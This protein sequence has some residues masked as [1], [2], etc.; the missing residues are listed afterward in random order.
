MQQILCCHSTFIDLSTPDHTGMTLLHYLAWSSKTSGEEFRKYH[1][2]SRTSL[3]AINAEGQTILHLAAQRGN[4]TIID[5]IAQTAKNLNELVN[6]RDCIGRTA[7]HLGTENKRTAD[8]ITLLLS[9]GADI[10]VRDCYGRSALHH[11]AKMGRVRAAETL[12]AARKP[13]M[14]SELYVVDIW[15]MT[16]VM[17]SAFYG[18]SDVAAW[19]RG[20]KARLMS[21]SQGGASESL[22]MQ[23][24]PSPKDK[25]F[26]LPTQTKTSGGRTL[27]KRRWKR[28]PDIWKL[29]RLWPLPAQCFLGLWLIASMVLIWRVGFFLLVAR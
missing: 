20:E 12:V 10:R 11:A 23:T 17:V 28:G 26:D 13:D 18:K 14:A 3:R 19:L 1:Q 5:Y 6:L 27:I 16:P 21:R 29:E 9:L 25:Y 2:L 22:S 24:A 7:L 15:G 8:A 4:L